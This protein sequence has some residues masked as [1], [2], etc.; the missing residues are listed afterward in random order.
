MLPKK[1]VKYRI[2]DFK[3]LSDNELENELDRLG[4]KINAFDEP[5]SMKAFKIYFGL[6]LAGYNCCK[7]FY[8]RFKIDDNEIVFREMLKSH[9]KNMNISTPISK[10]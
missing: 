7:E 10:N 9:L 6:M 4:D 2:T 8:K 3:K 5:N 1:I